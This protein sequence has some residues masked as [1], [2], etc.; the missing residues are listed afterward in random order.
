MLGAIKIY[1]THSFL[2]CSRNK[3]HDSSTFINQTIK[4]LNNQKLKLYRPLIYLLNASKASN[5]NDRR[6]L[7][8]YSRPRLLLAKIS[9]VKLSLYLLIQRL[10]RRLI[11]KFLL[12]SDVRKRLKLKR[13]NQLRRIRRKSRLLRRRIK[14]LKINRL[15]LSYLSRYIY[16]KIS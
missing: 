4:Y 5:S 14:R 13:Y 11:N 6:F 3:Q 2:Y 7:H 15:Y 16:A 10:L 1:A 8:S 9:V 12:K